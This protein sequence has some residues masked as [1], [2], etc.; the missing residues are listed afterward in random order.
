MRPMTL[1][2]RLAANIVAGHLLLV[3]AR[4]GAPSF[5]RGIL[6]MAF[7]GLLVLIVLE[8]AVSFIQRYVFMSLSSL[9]IREIHARNL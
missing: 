5:R 6:S 7:A 2:V 4:C 3:L 9:Y 8:V 1:G